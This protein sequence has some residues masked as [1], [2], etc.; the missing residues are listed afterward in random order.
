MYLVDGGWFGTFGRVTRYVWGPVATSF[1]RFFGVILVRRVLQE[2]YY[3]GAVFLLF[4]VS[5]TYSA[6]QMM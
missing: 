3:E 5:L 4:N 2:R 1:S 6:I